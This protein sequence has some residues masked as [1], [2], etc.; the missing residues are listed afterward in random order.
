MTQGGVRKDPAAAS[1]AI[2]TSMKSSRTEHIYNTLLERFGL[3]IPPKQEQSVGAK[4]EGPGGKKT[5]KDKPLDRDWSDPKVVTEA[6]CCEQCGMMPMEMDGGCCEGDYM[7]TE[8]KEDDIDEKAPPGY[9]KV[10]KGLKKDSDVDN[11]WAVAWSMK[12]KGIKPKSKR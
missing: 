3:P 5:W 2:L 10:V 7:E 6:S 12:N 9:E 8:L 1:C 11:P 4:D